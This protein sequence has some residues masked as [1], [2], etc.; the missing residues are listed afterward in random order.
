MGLKLSPKT[1]KI[2]SNFAINN[3]GMFFEEGNIQYTVS[4]INTIICQA[5][6]EENFPRSFAIY[7]LDT[8]LKFY[9]KFDDAELEFYDGYILIKNSK[10]S[11]K[12]HY[13]DKSVIVLPPKKP[14]DHEDVILR[15]SVN[16][17]LFAKL[18]SMCT[19]AAYLK[20]LCIFSKN[21]KIMLSLTN[22]D[23]KEIAINESEDTIRALNEDD[24]IQD[25][26]FFVQMETLK[27][28][29]GDYEFV[30]A[31]MVRNQN[32]IYIL[33]LVNSTYNVKYWTSLNT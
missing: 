9:D 10:S 8:F 25:F 7:G 24:V 21:G 12:Y 16:E 23:S 17:K 19:I 26:N 32:T 30:I 14:Y 29:D 15:F 3:P 20:H 11:F 5:T 13:A 22:K 18:R 28:L 6:L 1:Q 31:R 4:S 2:L 33:R 27:I